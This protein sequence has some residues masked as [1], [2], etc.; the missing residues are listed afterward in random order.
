M[1]VMA[2]CAAGLGPSWKIVESGLVSINHGKLLGI[3]LAGLIGI[4]GGYI[5]FRIFRSE[6]LRSHWVRVQAALRA[7]LRINAGTTMA[8]SLAFLIH[9][10]NF[11]IFY[12]FARALEIS[13]TYWQVLLIMPVVFLLLLLP[14]TVNGHGLREILLVFYFTEF[15]IHLGGGQAAG[16]PG[17]VVSLTLICVANDLLWSLPGGLLCL[18]PPLRHPVGKHERSIEC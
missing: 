14:V 4:T 7:G 8:L 1:V 5:L 3:F 15:G 16:V 18:V 9:F 6:A 13:I 17:I 11:A 12:L 2:G 10:L